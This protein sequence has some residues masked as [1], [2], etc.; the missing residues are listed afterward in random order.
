MKKTFLFLVTVL[1][2]CFTLVACQGGG[3]VSTP[4]DAPED[5]VTQTEG[6]TDKVTESESEEPN[7]SESESEPESEDIVESGSETEKGSETEV[8]SETESGS[9]SESEFEFD[10]TTES[11]VESA[12]DTD[13]ESES[14]SEGETE[15]P[16]L[17]L[18]IGADSASYVVSGIK[19]GIDG[20]VMIPAEYKGFP[21]LAIGKGAFYGSSI[22]GITIPDGVKR[23]EEEAF[24]GCASLTDVVIPDSVEHIGRSAFRDCVR[25][26]SMTVP[27]LGLGKQGITATYFGCIFGAEWYNDSIFLVP[28]SL[29]TVTVTSIDSV[30]DWA[31]AGCRYIETIILPEGVTSIGKYAFSGCESLKSLNL[32][33]GV[34]KVGDSAFEDC[35]V[36]GKRVDGVYYVGECAVSFD[37]TV[38]EV[39]IKD[40]TERIFEGAFK[41]AYGLT[42]ITIPASVTY[43][44]EG[45][46]LECSGLEVV[47]ISDLAKWC[48][49]E[50]V[51]LDSNPVTCSQALYLNGEPVTDLVIPDGV[52]AVSDRAFRGCA[53]ITSVTIPQGVKSI[54]ERA[55]F[56]CQ[57]L[58]SVNIS[59]TAESIGYLAFAACTKLEKIEVDGSNPNYKSIDGDLYSKDEKTLIQYAA[60]K[61]EDSFT[62]PETVTSIEAYAF[63]G[64]SLTNVMIPDG[65][66]S[67]GELAFEECKNISQ[68]E[69][70]NGYYLGN[71]ENPYV[72]LI[73]VS[74]MVKTSLKIHPKTKYIS[75]GSVESCHDL[76]EI[77]IPDGVTSIG[78]SAFMWCENVTE[79]TIP[80]SV[81]LIGES[82]F[83]G[84]YS[85]VTVNYAGSEDKWNSHAF[86]KAFAG[87]ENL[88]VNFNVIDNGQDNENEEGGGNDSD[89]E[90]VVETEESGLLLKLNDDRQSYAVVGVGTYQDVVLI[91]PESFNDLPVTVIGSGAFANCSFI[92]EVVIPESIEIIG[93][94]AFSG[95]T[96]LESVYFSEGL[97]RIGA[98]AFD[99]CTSINSIAVPDS[100]T[101][102]EAHAFAHCS[103]LEEIMLPFIGCYKDLSQTTDVRAAYFG[104]IFGYYGDPDDG[105]YIPSGLARVTVTSIDAINSPGFMLCDGIQVLTILSEISSVGEMSFYNCTGLQCVNY[106]GSAEQWATVTIGENNE[107]LT[108]AS[109]SYNYVP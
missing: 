55:F 71:E 13:T 105:T 34:T 72:C 12:S 25:L 66:L 26:E 38:N 65:I 50:F 108:N 95:C 84:C 81:V 86:G 103:G 31:F 37:K 98:F 21:V 54:G 51:G 87:L 59:G 96:S 57:N 48:Q 77:V 109:I 60:A 68:A 45:A 100:V 49:I 33:E 18:T 104:A 4:T 9:G 6:K 15:H 14:E 30:G 97:D 75:C 79:V 17:D 67:I 16:I 61:N 89:A 102:I 80:E 62:L 82:A 24:Y 56:Y 58:S 47:N 63:Y 44:G 41:N 2:V 76:K 88:T 22:T 28:E 46:F 90:I 23:I 70:E 20:H 94:S 83:Y 8:G 5:T 64:S 32:P 11:G 39:T 78:D 69:Y 52:D 27:Y 74:D 99:G 10:V 7:E 73:G 36:L 19:Q 53:T 35:Y 42:S 107:C 40:G 1:A 91:I 29:K 92:R 106:V 3:D 93:V 43:I 101:V 85:I